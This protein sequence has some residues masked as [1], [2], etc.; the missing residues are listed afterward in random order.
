MIL[1]DILDLYP[2]NEFEKVIGFDEAILGV[3]S[4]EVNVNEKYK[5]IYSVKKCIEILVERDKMTY[6][7][8]IEY[9]EFNTFGAYVGDQTPIW[10]QDDF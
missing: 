3:A 5:L 1:D 4:Y 7:E 9:L 8:A 6:S 10:C 2:E